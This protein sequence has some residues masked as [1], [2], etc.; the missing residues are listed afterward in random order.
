MITEEDVIYAYKLILGRDPESQ[1][2]IRN[3]V[4]SKDLQGF[5]KALIRSA[6]FDKKYRELIGPGPDIKV[7]RSDIQQEKIIFLH[8]PKTGGTTFHEILSSKYNPKDI[9]PERFNRLEH[10]KAGELAKYRMFSGHFDYYTVQLIPGENKKILT[11]F[12]RPKDRLISYYYFLKAHKLE[13]AELNKLPLPILANK[14][15]FSEFMESKELYRTPTIFNPYIYLLTGKKASGDYRLDGNSTILNEDDKELLSEAKSVV[16]NLYAFGILE[17]YDASV[18][19]ILSML[20]YSMED[21]IQ[22]KMV[23]EDLMEA[24]SH[25]KVEKEPLSLD[26]EKLIEFNTYLDEHLYQYAFS[27]FKSICAERNGDSVLT[28]TNYR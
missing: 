23:L 18:Q 26:T 15:T 27:K 25:K 11:F 6:E 20:G 10:H 7:S 5:R 19:H 24:E 14:Y 13:R 2:A 22:K 8:I 1:N 12:R 16:N 17:K 28:S 21:K 3:H 4:K 9:C